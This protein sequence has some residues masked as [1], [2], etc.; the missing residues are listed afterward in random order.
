MITINHTWISLV[1]CLSLC[2]LQ[3][4]ASP[5]GSHHLDTSHQPSNFTCISGTRWHHVLHVLQIYNF[6][7]GT[8]MLFSF[9]V[10]RFK[11]NWFFRI[12][13]GGAMITSTN[14]FSKFEYRKSSII[15]VCMSTVVDVIVRKYVRG[16]KSKML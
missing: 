6:K 10:M 8:T 15:R 1:P 12:G 11:F 14:A 16:V 5:N 2:E 7:F 3:K 13:F 9:R 4:S